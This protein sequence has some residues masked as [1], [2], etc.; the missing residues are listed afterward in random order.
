M[1][2]AFAR[3]VSLEPK[4]GGV[5]G[6]GSMKGEIRIP[7]GKEMKK[8]EAEIEELFEESKIFPPEQSRPRQG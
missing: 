1:T 3:I 2:K 5:S 7:S 6:R 4:R 8:L